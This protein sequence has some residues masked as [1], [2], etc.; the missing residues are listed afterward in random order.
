[1]EQVIQAYED[2]RTT[3][4]DLSCF[5]IRASRD[6][7]SYFVSIESKRGVEVE[8]GKVKIPIGGATPCGYGANYEFDKAGN[9]VKRTGIR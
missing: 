7:D 3:H 2:F 6:G 9:F 1:M 5:K 8:D 4:D